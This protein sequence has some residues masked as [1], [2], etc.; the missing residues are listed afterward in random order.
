M[1]VLKKNLVL[2]VLSIVCLLI[3][4]AGI[5]LTLSE[6]GKVTA[7]REK[8][9][10][11]ESQLKNLLNA[12]PAPTVENVEASQANVLQLEAQLKKIRDNLQQGSGI[13]VSS[14]GI[15]VMASIQQFISEYQRRFAD[16]T[17]TI[18]KDETPFVLP[19]KFAFGFEQY[20]DQAAPPTDPA[21]VA[22][23]DKQRQIISY[24]L[25]Q[26]IEVNPHS[27]KSVQRHI[28]EKT[29][30]NTGGFS[31][32][33]L[34]TAAVPGAIDT[35]A[36]SITFTGY[37]NSLRGFLNNLAKFEMPLV[38]RD[39][40]VQRPSGSETVAADAAP[41]GFEALFG[42]STT[43]TDSAKKEEQKPVISENVSSFTVVLEYIDIV[44]PFESVE[45]SPE[46]VENP[47]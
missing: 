46:S 43:A 16:I 39:I 8:I 13:V 40:E 42:E 37:S 20:I 28:Y 3:F 23:L 33:P 1:G 26:L 15:G 22:K 7:A 14:D 4:A 2:V 34:V 17:N 38:V 12:D 5:F 31:V 47:S 36:F 9:N 21:A 24:I 6:S 10:S 45:A 25:D 35:M 19:Q 11:A 29:G 32:D 27:I 41:S 30:K 18:D 44:L